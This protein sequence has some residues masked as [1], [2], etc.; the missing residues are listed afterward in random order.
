MNLLT[1]AA[2]IV[3]HPGMQG[4]IIALTVLSG[5]LRFASLPSGVPLGTSQTR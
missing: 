3:S 1:L 5:F 4:E 2:V